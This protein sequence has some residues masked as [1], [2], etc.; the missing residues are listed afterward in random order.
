[1]PSVLSFMS[2]NCKTDSGKTLKKF[3]KIWRIESTKI[4]NKELYLF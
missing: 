3:L 2:E 4:I 1:M